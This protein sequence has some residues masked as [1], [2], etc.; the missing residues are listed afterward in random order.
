MTFKNK[1]SAGFGAAL[2]TLIFV[3]VLSYRSMVQNDADLQW[4]TH[5][6]IVKEK[7]DAVLDNLLDIETGERG[8]I[9]TGEGSYLEPY[10]EALGTSATKT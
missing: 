6:H 5:T 9:I 4:V 2:A 8:Y 3:G 10:K 1:I 7:L